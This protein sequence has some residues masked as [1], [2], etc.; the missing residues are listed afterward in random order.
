MTL[1][2]D[3]FRRTLIC[4]RRALSSFKP[5][6]KAG[7]CEILAEHWNVDTLRASQILSGELSQEDEA[8]LEELNDFDFGEF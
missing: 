6:E 8:A 3:M 4:L 1:D 2:D 5:A 7:V